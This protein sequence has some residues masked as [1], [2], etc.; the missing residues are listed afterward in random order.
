M[1]FRSDGIV[2]VILALLPLWFYFNFDTLPAQ[3]KQAM[4]SIMKSK[5]F[6]LISAIFLACF[7]AFQIAFGA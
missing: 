1:G 5:L 6:F 7:G 2:M 3:M 4:P